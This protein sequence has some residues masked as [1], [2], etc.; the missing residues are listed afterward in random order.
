MSVQP[1]MISCCAG[2]RLSS[3][4]YTISCPA[5]HLTQDPPFFHQKTGEKPPK[6]AKIGSDPLYFPKDPTC[7]PPPPPSRK[8]QLYTPAV[9][10]AC[11]E[12]K[13]HV[14]QLSVES[15]SSHPKATKQYWREER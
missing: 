7:F 14:H 5:A 3:K 4:V 12:K 8:L 15:E 1:E 10:A 9:K 11:R 2:S 6:K 13:Q